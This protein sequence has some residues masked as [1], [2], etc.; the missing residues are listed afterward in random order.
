MEAAMAELRSHVG[1][2]Y[3]KDV[4]ATLEKLLI[5]RGNQDLLDLIGE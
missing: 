2:K 4:V 5:D 1:A 3:D